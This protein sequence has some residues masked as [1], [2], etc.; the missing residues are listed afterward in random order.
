MTATPNFESDPELRQLFV[1]GMSNAAC[2]VSVVTTD[3]AAGRFGV[4][5]SA[6]A[7][8]SADTEKPTLL[9][10]IHTLSPAAKAIMENGAFC[11]NV[12]RD[13]QSYI[14][15]C[16]A[17]KQKTANGDR[18]SCAQWTRDAVGAP[19]VADALVAF[20]CKL[21]S[22]Q[23]I[24]THHVLFGAVEEIFSA[25]PGSPLI[26]ANRAYG[27]P[28]RIGMISGGQSAAASAGRLNLGVFHT[29]A[30]YVVPEILERLE[31]AGHK[32]E[33]KLL[34]GDQ[35][36]II[37]GLQV[38]EVDLALLYYLALHDSFQV[39]RLAALDPYVLLAEGDPLAQHASLSLAELSKH[40]MILLD[41]PP[42]GDY[43]L[44]LFRDKNLEPEIRLRSKS[45]EMVRGIVGRGIG[46]SLL[47]TKPA[48]N[49]SYDG[50]ALT[51]RPLRDKAPPSHIALARRPDGKSNPVADLFASECRIFFR[52]F[53][54]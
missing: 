11:V 34:E 48:S 12:L 42:S 10:C 13:D 8:V 14:S 45:F 5:V 18:F 40:P 47:A 27:S 44:S 46:Y 50:R 39:E 24:G 52:S 1:N 7:S 16:F 25:G 41:A 30:P 49:M 22:N 54:D 35:R 21:L 51:T 19:R 29:F 53:N 4:T 38:G 20:S 37:E 43:F 31:L 17:G 33:L 32:I 2:T 3:G 36:T 15:D 26:Y 9:V 23:Q 6:M 28:A